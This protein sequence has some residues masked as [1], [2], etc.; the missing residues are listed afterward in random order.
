MSV[1]PP[2]MSTT[3]FP[4]GSV[5][6][7]PGADRGDHGL[8]DKVNLR[9][10]RSVGR[11]HNSA[12][13]Y[14]RD[15][16]R[17]ADDD[18]RMHHHLAVVRLLDEVV[19]HLLGVAEV[20]DNAVLHRFDGDDVAWR[21]AKHVLGLLADGLDLVGDLV[22]R[23]N[24]RLVMCTARATMFCCSW[25]ISLALFLQ[26]GFCNTERSQIAILSGM[27]SDSPLHA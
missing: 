8:F 18:A 6:G 25:S 4:P 24:R 10:F 14:L 11:V 1:V 2:P 12:L 19:Q 21:A 26:S 17:N 23:N 27:L 15:L 9:R 22:H 13:L 3:I 20:G 16:R 7:K 5:I